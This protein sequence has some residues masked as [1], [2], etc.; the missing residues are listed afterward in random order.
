MNLTDNYI[1]IANLPEVA[2]TEIQDFLE[3]L[4]LKYTEQL[5]PSINKETKNAKKNVITQLKRISMTIGKP[6]IDN[7][8][9]WQKEIR[10]DKPFV[11]REE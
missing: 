5:R 4:T 9:I 8:I 11:G 2:R 7:P 6:S 1:N 10:K 3:F